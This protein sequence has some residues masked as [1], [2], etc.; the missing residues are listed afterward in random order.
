MTIK[1]V[2]QR[3]NSSS[4]KVQQQFRLILESG[5]LDSDDVD[6]IPLREFLIQFDLGA[7]DSTPMATGYFNQC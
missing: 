1:E 7:V 4:E 2:L 3:F 6:D 5:L